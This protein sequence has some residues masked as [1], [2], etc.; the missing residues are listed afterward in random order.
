[1]KAVARPPLRLS[2][3]IVGALVLTFCG[4]VFVRL[5]TV[6]GQF[7]DLFR[8]FGADLPLFTQ[9]FIS[10]VTL[11]WVTVL[12]TLA[13]Q[14]ILFVVYIVDRDPRV[15]RVFWWMAFVNLACVATLLV[16]MYL[17]IFKLGEVV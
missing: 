6:M 9:W 8:G 4:G 1:M 5:P 7:V 12:A 3:V 2:T 16:A 17:P 14:L 10:H 11:I 13:A 15:R